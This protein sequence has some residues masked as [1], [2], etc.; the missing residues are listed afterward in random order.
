MFVTSPEWLQ[1][2]K[3]NNKK[4]NF[5]HCAGTCNEKHILTQNQTQSGSNSQITK[6]PSPWNWQLGWMII[7]VLYLPTL[8]PKEKQATVAFDEVQLCSRNLTKNDTPTRPTIYLQRNTYPVCVLGRICLHLNLKSSETIL[9]NLYQEMKRKIF[10]KLSFT[11]SPGTSK[12]FQ[13]NCHC[14][15]HIQKNNVTHT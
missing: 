7:T 11:Y 9:H 10:Q 2:V 1:T 6:T 12:W 14:V 4:W 3:E 8:D 5:P 13:H 15:S